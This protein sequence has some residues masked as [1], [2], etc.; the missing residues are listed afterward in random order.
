MPSGT[1]TGAGGLK[2]GTLKILEGG[3]TPTYFVNIIGGDLTGADITLTTPTT[4]GTLALTSDFGVLET[5]PAFNAWLIATPPLYSESDTLDSVTGRGDT[6]TNAINTGKITADSVSG[7]VATNF[8]STANATGIEIVTTDEELGSGHGTASGYVGSIGTDGSFPYLRYG[9]ANTSWGRT[10]YS[11]LNAEG[12]PTGNYDLIVPSGAM[13]TTGSQINLYEKENGANYT[14]LRSFRTLANNL[15]FTFPSDY[16]ASVGF[17]KSDNVG[18]MSFDTNTY[19]T[20]ETD[21]LASVMAR[22]ATTGVQLASTLATGTSP[23]SITST[24]VNTNLNADLLD[25]QN[26]S[27]LTPIGT[28][29]MYGAATAPTGW[30]LC[31]GTS[32]SKTGAY[33]DLYAVIGTTFGGNFTSFNVPDMRGNFPLGYKSGTYAMGATGGA[34]TH[35]HTPTL[36]SNSAGTPAGTIDTHSTRTVNAVTPTTTVLT[37]PSTHTFTGSAMSSHTHTPSLSTDSG[38]PPYLVLQYIIKY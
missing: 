27:D 7:D 12:T 11:I 24:T 21:T 19:L 5:D 35:T 22:G 9:T 26:A 8:K 28:I 37:G 6:T 31:D 36:T 23:F 10:A 15:I 3:T 17:W 4:T 18:R 38:M 20:A 13:S 32:Y 14:A 25:G 30:L 29:V 2:L 33:A 16:P 1:I 34:T